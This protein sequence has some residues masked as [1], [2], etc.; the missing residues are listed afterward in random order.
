MLVLVVAQV[1]FQIADKLLKL[2]RWLPLL[3]RHVKLVLRE[4]RRDRLDQVWTDDD[5]RRPGRVAA[6][7]GGGRIAACGE[8]LAHSFQQHVGYTVRYSRR[9]HEF[10]VDDDAFIRVEDKDGR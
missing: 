6:P 7:R 3:N 4:R 1:G 2:L 5:C 8:W 9:L 10:G